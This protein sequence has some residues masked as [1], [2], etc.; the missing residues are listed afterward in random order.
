MAGHNPII[1]WR[2]RTLIGWDLKPSDMDKKH[3]EALKS[4]FPTVQKTTISTEL[5]A[6]ITKEAMSLPDR[7]KKYEVVFSETDIPLPEHRGRLDHEIK[8]TESFKPK[9]G[10]IYPLSMKEKEELNEF[11]NENLACG[12]I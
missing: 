9:K 3:P 8:L 10:S 11:L 6:K 7:Y 1:N 5:E 2:T 12:K 4:E